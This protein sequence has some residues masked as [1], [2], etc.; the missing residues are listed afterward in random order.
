MVQEGV[1][2]IQEPGDAAG[3]DVPRHAFSGIE[4]ERPLRVALAGQ[5]RNGED[6]G[7]IGNRNRAHRDILFRDSGVGDIRIRGVLIE[8]LE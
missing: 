4:V 3:L 8:S 7:E 1:A 2:A 5:W 6:T